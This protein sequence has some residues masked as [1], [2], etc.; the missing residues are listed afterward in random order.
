MGNSLIAEIEKYI[1]EHR[2][3]FGISRSD[4]DRL[5]LTEIGVIKRMRVD[6]LV[7]TVAVGRKPL[8]IVKYFPDVQM[9]HSLIQEYENILRLGEMGLRDITPSPVLVNIHNKN[10]VIERYLSGVTIQEV[11]KTKPFITRSFLKGFANEVFP[12]IKEVYIKLNS[13]STKA[14]KADLGKDV[15]LLVDEYCRVFQYDN[16]EKIRR[17]TRLFVEKYPEERISKRTVLFDAYPCNMLFDLGSRKAYLIDL[18]YI[19][20]STL[21]FLEPIRAAFFFLKYSYEYT[22]ILLFVDRKEFTSAFFEGNG[23]LGN[24]IKVFLDENTVMGCTKDFDCRRGLMLIF[25]MAEALLQQEAVPILW[26]EKNIYL[27]FVD[28]FVSSDSQQMLQ[29]SLKS[30]KI[31]VRRGVTRKAFAYL[32]RGEVKMIFKKFEERFL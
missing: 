21:N 30:E 23:W 10:I 20:Y 9:E 26:K 27:K 22:N 6:K 13:V 17:I 18:E 7:Y 29:S 28:I 4:S 12:L 24:L 1:K 15:N 11:F 16:P 3:Q 32:M 25:F 8:L 31:V 2:D 5:S 19:D 14:D